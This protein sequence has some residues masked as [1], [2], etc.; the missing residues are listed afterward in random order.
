MLMNIIIY[1]HVR[2]K[3]THFY[4]KVIILN[5]QFIFS[6]F[7]RHTYRTSG[8]RKF[9]PALSHNV[10]YQKLKPLRTGIERTFGLVKGNRYRM[11]EETNFYRGIHTVE[12]DIAPHLTQ[13]IIFDYLTTGKKSPVLKPN[14]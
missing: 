7:L 3:I 8:Y 13:D 12:H 1:I 4:A 5:V 11:E 14:Y 6:K 2:P 9:G 10:I